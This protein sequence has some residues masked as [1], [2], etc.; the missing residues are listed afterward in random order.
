MVVR[1][2]FPAGEDEMIEL[3]AL[4]QQYLEGDYDPEESTM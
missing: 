4:R 3:A 1:G 2:Y